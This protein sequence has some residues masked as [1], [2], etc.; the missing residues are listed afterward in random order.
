MS[1]WLAEAGHCFLVD[2]S[3]ILLWSKVIVISN[4]ATTGDF[5]ATQNMRHR[6]QNFDDFD[7]L[8]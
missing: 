7:L 4:T 1:K 3:T 8:K 5:T 2:A 6:C